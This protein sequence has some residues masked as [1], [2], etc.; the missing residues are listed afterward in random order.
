MYFNH[1]IDH[2][3]DGINA[4]ESKGERE[5][6]MYPRLREAVH[7]GDLMTDDIEREKLPG[8]P[9]EHAEGNKRNGEADQLGDGFALLGL[10]HAG[11]Q[12]RAYMGILVGGDVCA[13]EVHPES[14]SQ[15]QLFGTVE[16][17]GKDVSFKGPPYD[18]R[19]H[20]GAEHEGNVF[21]DLDEAVVDFF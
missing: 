1:S 4:G 21:A 7:N 3:G 18:H 5:H 2:M 9:C 11:E 15:D 10:E 12:V 20:D 17:A 13:D 16:L 14:D 6:G 8:Q 19:A